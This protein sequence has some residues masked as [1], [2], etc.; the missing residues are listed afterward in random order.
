MRPP[1]TRPAGG[2]TPRRGWLAGTPGTVVI[3]LALATVLGL[4]SS[5]PC[6]RARPVDDPPGIEAETAAPGQVAHVEVRGP[7]IVFVGKDA[8]PVR[9]RVSMPMLPELPELPPMPSLPALPELPEL[10]ELPPMPEFP[11]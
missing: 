1:V 11:H 4:L 7:E 8:G 6:R 10:P 3:L 2:F 9:E 5:G